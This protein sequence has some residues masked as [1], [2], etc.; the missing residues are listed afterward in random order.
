MLSELADMV[1]DNRTI[2]GGALTDIDLLLLFRPAHGISWTAPR[3]M[4]AGDILF[5]Y[6]TRS[7]Q[8]NAAR[9]A[10]QLRSGALGGRAIVAAVERANVQAAR[11]ARTIFACAEV[12]GRSTDVPN[13]EGSQHFRSTI[14]APLGA[15]HVFDEPLPSTE[16]TRAVTLSTGGT[17]TPVH[18]SA[19]TQL[20][21]LL[22]TH[23]QLPVFLRDAVPGAIG[24]RNVTR[25]NWPTI[26]TRPDRVFLDE[27]QLRAYLLDYLLAEIKDQ[28]TALLEECECFRAGVATGIADYFVQVHGRWIP[29]EAKLNVRAERDLS[30]QVRKYGQI[31]AFQPRRGPTPR[32]RYATQRGGT[33]LVAD[34]AGLYVLVDGVYIGCSADRPAWARAALSHATGALVRA[35]L[36]ELL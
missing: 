4:T 10:H 17:L 13:E 12:S 8:K 28:R 36:A 26:S 33:C 1:E 7:G 30:G 24:F 6:H 18:G 15:V 5:F 20:K 23:N 11:Y 25:E 19:L 9:I 35:R 2:V 34:Q 14:Y 22:A 16:F 32:T 31:D 3:W 21:A 27:S 29:V